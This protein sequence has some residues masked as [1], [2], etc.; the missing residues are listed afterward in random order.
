MREFPEAITIHSHE[1]PWIYAFTFTGCIF[2]NFRPFCAKKEYI[3]H[4]AFGIRHSAFGIRHSAFGIRHS[5]FG[6]RHS[7]L[8]SGHYCD[9]LPHGIAIT[10]MTSWSGLHSTA[11]VHHV[12]GWGGGGWS[13]SGMQR[14]ANA[15]P[16]LY[17]G[18]SSYSTTSVVCLFTMAS[19]AAK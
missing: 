16:V 19:V 14:R 2:S 7:A 8:R 9:L 15:F 17:L 12:F 18:R 10:L 13:I 4:S 3:R 11:A 1:L 5:A 6:I